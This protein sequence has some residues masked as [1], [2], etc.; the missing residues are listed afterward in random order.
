[1]R[2]NLLICQKLAYCLSDTDLLCGVVWLQA[3][4]GGS[5]GLLA[6]QVNCRV[7]KRCRHRILLEGCPH[8]N[9]FSMPS[10]AAAL[11]G[12]LLKR[13]MTKATLLWC[14]RPSMVHEQCRRFT[15]APPTCDSHSASQPGICTSSAAAHSPQPA[16]HHYMHWLVPC[17]LI[18]THGMETMHTTLLAP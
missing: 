11:T 9:A 1:M 13:A 10:V 3:R 17:F 2:S 4:T 12:D 14:T 15:L 8:D 5:D 18:T 7:Q 16:A 6:L